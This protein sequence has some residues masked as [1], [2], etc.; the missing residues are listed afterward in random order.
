MNSK[1]YNKNNRTMAHKIWAI[2]LALVFVVS[3]FLFVAELIDSDHGQFEG[4]EPS[5]DKNLLYNGREYVI[6]EDVET[7]LVLGLDKFYSESVD[8]YNNDKQ[9]D[10][11]M[12]FIVD[13]NTKSY[14]ALH[15]NRDAMVEMNVLGVAGDKIDTTTKQ[16]AIAHTY[17]NG[18]E[19]SCRNVANAVSGMLLGAEID[20]YVSVTMDSVSVYNDLLGG[21]SLEILDDFTSVDDTMVKGQ[22]VT[23]SGEQALKYVRSRQGIDDST[24]KSRMARQKQYLNALY[25]KTKETVSNDSSFVSKTGLAMSKYVISDCSVNKLEQ[26][27]IKLS[28]YKL[29]EVLDIEGETTIGEEFVEFYPNEDSVLEIV[30]DCFYKESK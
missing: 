29:D 12:L 22:T 16:L 27:M 7:I 17:G 30:I 21:V 13:N 2:V 5:L 20:H 15:L 9:A 1:E 10:F 25:D 14:K 18:K 3:A 11:L 24:N 28:E 26:F 6:D 19:V 4:D 23:L 8:S